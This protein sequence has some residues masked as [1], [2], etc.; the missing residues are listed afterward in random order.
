MSSCR[1]TCA[2]LAA[3]LLFGC[4]SKKQQPQP[5]AASP[6]VIR[7]IEQNYRK[8]NP[9]A[10]V[11][12]VVEILPDANLAAIADVAVGDFAENDVV[13]FMDASRN[14]IA[15]GRVLNTVANHLA[16]KYTVDQPGQRAPRKG[17]LMLR[18]K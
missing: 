5:Q 12:Q 11:G 10:R 4:Q 9:G 15:Y 3:G 7:S 8:V 16:V 2:L 1:I 17:D 14:V 13:V 6:A 18:V